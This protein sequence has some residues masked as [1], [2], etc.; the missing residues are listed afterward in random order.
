MWD[1]EGEAKYEYTYLTSVGDAEYPYLCVERATD[2]SNLE[3]GATARVSAWKNMSPIVAEQPERTIDD[4]LAS[5]SP[6]DKEIIKE[7]LK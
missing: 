7:A 5:L 3:G 4:I 6:E 2:I 1:S